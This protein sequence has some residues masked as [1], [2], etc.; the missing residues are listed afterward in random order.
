MDQTQALYDDSQANEILRTAVR[1]A[2]PSEI[3]FEEM[4]SAASELGISRDELKDAEAQYKKNSSEEGVKAGFRAMQGH[5]FKLSIFHAALLSGI[6]LLITLVDV[7]PMAPLMALYFAGFVV[8]FA[9]LFLL[10][11]YRALHNFESKRNKKAF[12]EWLKRKDVWLR[13][14]KAKEIVDQIMENKLLHWPP[15][16]G[17]PK[18]ATIQALRDGLGYDKKR[19]ITVYDAYLREHPELEAKL[20]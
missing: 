2:A 3:T 8:V 15:G 13:P 11:R 12:D 18:E 4:V 6:A 17:S 7:S 9:C 10:L 5:E 1:L 20:G 16:N 19:A 14:E